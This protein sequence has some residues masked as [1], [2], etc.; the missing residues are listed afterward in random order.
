MPNDAHSEA[1]APLRCAVCAAWLL[2]VETK[3]GE[4]WAVHRSA[5]PRGPEC[6]HRG[7][8]FRVPPPIERGETEGGNGSE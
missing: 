7:K 3:G 5:N 2:L 6:P 8:G 4:V 1:L